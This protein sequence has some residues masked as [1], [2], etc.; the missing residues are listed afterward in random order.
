MHWMIFIIVWWLLPAQLQGLD[1]RR[2]ENML[3][4]EQIFY[5]SI[6]MKRTQKN[7]VKPWQV[8]SISKCS[9]L[10]ADFS[11]LSEVHAVAKQL[12]FLDQKY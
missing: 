6:A 8:N 3:L 4:M 1:M 5:V 10:I 12:S 11:K 7:Y 9:Y 2:R